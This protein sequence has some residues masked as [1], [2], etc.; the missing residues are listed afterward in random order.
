MNDDK[1]ISFFLVSSPVKNQSEFKFQRQNDRALTH[2]NSGKE[3]WF[4][5]NEIL[6]DMKVLEK[7]LTDKFNLG[8]IEIKDKMN[9]LNQNRIK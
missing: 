5:K 8:N 9:N 3:I 7:T 6:K 4:F 1:I 2:V